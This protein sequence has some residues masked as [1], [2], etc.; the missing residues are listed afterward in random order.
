M[1]NSFLRV[2]ELEPIKPG[3]TIPDKAPTKTS[4]VLQWFEKRTPPEQVVE[5]DNLAH[6]PQFEKLRE[7]VNAAKGQVNDAKIASAQFETQVIDE[8]RKFDE[9]VESERHRLQDNIDQAELLL[10]TLDDHAQQYVKSVWPEKMLV[11]DPNAE[12]TAPDLPTH[13]PIENIEE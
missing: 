10:G 6:L 2:K 7:K 13:T 4:S 8:R 5:P 9:Y 11:D 12:P 3:E 1:S